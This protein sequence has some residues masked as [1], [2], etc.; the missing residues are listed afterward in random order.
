M[1]GHNQ[2]GGDCRDRPGESHLSES[3]GEH[4][5]ARHRNI[6]IA[7]VQL[8]AERC[9]REGNEFELALELPCE[10]VSHVDVVAH[11]LVPSIEETIGEIVRVISNPQHPPVRD[12]LQ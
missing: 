7:A 6:K 3:R 12:A 1:V 5:N 2:C 9:K 8:F 11:Q 4:R 10:M